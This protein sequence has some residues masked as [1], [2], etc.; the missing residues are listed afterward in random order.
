MA[1]G[2]SLPAAAQTDSAHVAIPDADRA[3]RLYVRGLTA[4]RTGD[5]EQAVALFGEA[6][7]LAPDEPAIYLSLSESHSRLN[8]AETALFYGERAAA[9]EADLTNLSHLA[10]LQSA[11][12]RLSDAEATYDRIVT[13]YPD[14]AK[15]VLER[16][17]LKVRLGREA[18]AADAFERLIRLTGDDRVLRTRLLQL[19][20]RINDLTGIERTLRAL[21]ELDDENAHYHLMLSDFLIRHDREAEALDVLERAVEHNPDD[22]NLLTELEV[23]HRALGASVA[24][25]SLSERLTDVDG[26]TADEIAARAE[27]AYLTA[28]KD[29]AATGTAVGLL[30]KGLELDGGHYG[31]LTMLGDLRFRQGDF[32]ESADLLARALRSDPREADVWLQATLAYLNAD[33]PERAAEIG[34]EAIILFPGRVDLF[35]ATAHAYFVTYQNSRS[36]ELYQHALELLSDD[37]LWSA[38]MA[39]EAHASL[40]FLFSR[41]SQ[42]DRSDHHYR[43]ALRIDSTHVFALNNF[44]YNL[45]TRRDHLNE[46]LELARRAVRLQPDSPS[47]QDTLGWVLFQLDRPDEA[48]PYLARAVDAAPDNPT[49]LE[50]LGDVEERLGR[51]DSARTRWARALEL[52][53][54]SQTLREKLARTAP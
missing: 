37:E 47:L 5:H 38:G 30:A 45:A 3:V 28:I 31:M 54:E 8:D 29:S 53:P 44:A 46:A 13:E 39:A 25:D 1:G 32:G 33:Q 48:H 11:T 6:A 51:L 41:R 23:L 43:A 9:L 19:Y 4:A 16:A 7:Q 50:H 12:G 20:G 10:R 27:R 52:D 40:G 17:R 2:L 18:E 34:E 21:I 22:F 26:L 36:I 42:N 14:D 49:I 15:A 24:A 35:E